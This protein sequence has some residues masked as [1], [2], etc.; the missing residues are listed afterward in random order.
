LQQIQPFLAPQDG[1]D[2]EHNWSI[3][4]EHEQRM[5]DS[6]INRYPENKLSIAEVLRATR[7]FASP[8]RVQY[9][10]WRMVKRLW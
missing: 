9:I 2:P 5:I 4:A 7:L 10:K 3:V 6:V 8:S 1:Y